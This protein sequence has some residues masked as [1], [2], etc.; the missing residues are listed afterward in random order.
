MI[1]IDDDLEKR[2]MLVRLIADRL[3]ATDEWKQWVRAQSLAAFTEMTTMLDGFAPNGDAD[4][5]RAKSL[6]DGIKI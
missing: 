2:V 1:R 3:R 4:I 6:K 5:S